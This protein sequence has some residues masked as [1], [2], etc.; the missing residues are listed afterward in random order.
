MFNLKLT[1]KLLSNT[2]WCAEYDG[3]V[4]YSCNPQKLSITY[5]EKN[6]QASPS[7]KKIISYMTAV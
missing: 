6:M 3:N 7:L 2:W 1:N 5:L 4:G